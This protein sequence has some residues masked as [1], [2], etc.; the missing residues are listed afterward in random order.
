M[1][2][3]ITF[4]SMAALML[5]IAGCSET[6]KDLEAESAKDT[7]KGLAALSISDYRK[8]SEFF[9]EAAKNSATNFD[10]RINLAVAYM[11]LGEMNK[12]QSAIT[13]AIALNPDSA[14]ARLLE[15]QIAYQMRDYGF[16]TKTF[17]TIAKAKSL[18]K[19]MR[20]TAYT[21]LAIVDL[22]QNKFIP[23]RI[24]LFRAI[25]LNPR[26]AVAWYH[27][28][29]MSRDTYKLPDAALEQFEMA[30]RLSNPKDPRTVKITSEIMPSIR[31]AIA[32]NAAQMPGAANRKPEEAAKLL[33]EGKAASKKKHFKTALKKYTEAY[34]AD[35]MSFE[36]A[37]AYARTLS[38]QDKTSAAADKVLEAYNAAINQ[39][40][41]SQATYIEAGKFAY[42]RKRYVTT[43][44]IMNRAL[45]HAHNNKQILD[46]LIAS[47]LKNLPKDAAVW[48]EYR[49]EL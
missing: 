30:S 28:G 25:N 43:A 45:A 2:S 24:S 41:F 14:E 26:N 11:Q 13:N 12:A 48:Q 7:E 8:A 22:A 5:A 47:L 4:F 9:S 32:R 10:A 42:G 33:A 40:P 46:L 23:A 37:I 1:N 38:S 16:A 36:A 27:L 44:K 49:N 19:A 20:S 6:Q 39:K 15:G 17:S 29:V 21:S 34:K 35:P 31:N 18:D 3:V